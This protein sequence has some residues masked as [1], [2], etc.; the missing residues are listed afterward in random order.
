MLFRS[1]VINKRLFEF[2][3]Q[4]VVN[5]QDQIWV[6]DG[7]KKGIWSWKLGEEPKLIVSGDPLQNPVGLFLVDDQ[8]AIVDPHART[9]FKWTANG[10]SPWFSID[11]K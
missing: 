1:P 8:P 4:V 5:S 10:L 2:P 3:H 7:Y 11:N 6:T 9:V